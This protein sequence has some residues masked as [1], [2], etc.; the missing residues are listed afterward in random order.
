MNPAGPIV[1]GADGLASRVFTMADQRRFAEFCGDVNPMHMDPVSAR[2]TQA[3]VPAVHG[4]HLLL[5]ALDTALADH[6]RPVAGLKAHFERFLPVETLV[7]LHLTQKRGGLKLELRT[8]GRR[9]AYA[10]ISFGD[11]APAAPVASRIATG[12]P[13]SAAVLDLKG[14]AA[15]TGALSIPN[16]NAAALGFINVA[17]LLGPARVRALAALSTLVGMVTPGMHSILAS[18][19]VQMTGLDTDASV[20]VLGYEAVSAHDAFSLITLEATG[21]GLRAEVEAFLRPAPVGQPSLADLGVFVPSGAYAGVRALVVGGS[22]GLGELT[23]KLIVAGGGCVALTYAAGRDDA[24]RVSAEL[25][26]SGASC[27]ILA[28][29][30]LKPAVNQLAELS[31]RPN[32]VYYFATPRIFRQRTR[33]YAPA[34]FAEYVRVY[35]DGLY[36]LCAAFADGEPVRVFYPSSVAVE[37]RPG[38][39]TEYAMAKSASE[40]LCADIDRGLPGVSVSVERLPR[41]ETDQTATLTAVAAASSVEVMNAVVARMTAPKGRAS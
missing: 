11:P 17:G 9:L 22:R 21:P 38:E 37:E 12:P 6:G 13:A 41:L 29:D 5:W 2:R 26:V 33:F 28:Y 31:F 30:A 4:M 18:I 40:A 32:Q 19:D 3:G 23:A 7:S 24:E 25:Q 27:S 39:L 8:D 15:A 35:C 36:D 10:T 34:L 16:R 1:D 14:A 20:E